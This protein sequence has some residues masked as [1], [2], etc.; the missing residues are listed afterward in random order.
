[1]WEFKRTSQQPWKIHIAPLKCPVGKAEVREGHLE[2]VWAI[3][4]SHLTK[5]TVCSPSF[6]GYFHTCHSGNVCKAR[7]AAKRG[8]GRVKCPHKKLEPCVSP[9]GICT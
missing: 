9:C 2:K 5:F 8:A 7:D 1:M 4:I 6:S 3:I